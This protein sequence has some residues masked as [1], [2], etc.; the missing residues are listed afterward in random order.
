MPIFVYSNFGFYSLILF[1]FKL[2]LLSI[3]KATVSMEGFVVSIVF[4]LFGEI[5]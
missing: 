5:N 1:K 2:V 3:L 4:A